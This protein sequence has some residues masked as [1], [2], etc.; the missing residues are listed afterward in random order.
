MVLVNVAPF[1]LLKLSVWK[2]LDPP[3]AENAC[4]DCVV[5]HAGWESETDSP[6]VFSVIDP[7]IDAPPV[8]PV[9]VPARAA[10]LNERPFEFSVIAAPPVIAVAVPAYP[11]AS[12][13][14]P[15]LFTV[16]VT[17]V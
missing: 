15:E 2:A 12:S 5:I 13:D 14:S 9:F 17:F 4:P 11:E 8:N 7:L 1:A 16:Q 6:A 3:P 10:P